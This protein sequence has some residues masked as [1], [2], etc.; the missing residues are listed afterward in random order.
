MGSIK[1]FVTQCAAALVA[2]PSSAEASCGDYVVPRGSHL[3]KSMDAMPLR[4]FALPLTPPCNSPACRGEVPQ[5]P[6]PSA[7]PDFQ[8]GEKPLA[9]FAAELPLESG[10]L[11]GDWLQEREHAR[12]G[13]R[14]PLERPPSL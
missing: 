8:L 4:R 13:Y 14:L 5:L 10:G 7:P 3:A 6:V 2:W 12:S 1:K 9:L 11:S